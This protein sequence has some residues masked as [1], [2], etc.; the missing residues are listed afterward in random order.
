M[1]EYM[2]LEQMLETRNWLHV[3]STSGLTNKVTKIF[4]QI[5]GCM[6]MHVKG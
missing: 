3:T 6:H 4:V 1:T 2:M 5:A